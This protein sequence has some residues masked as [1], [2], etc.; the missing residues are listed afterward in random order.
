MTADWSPAT[1]SLDITTLGRLYRSGALKPTD[2]I[3][4]IYDRI[5]ARGDDHVWI[6]LAPRDA[7]LQHAAALESAGP[8]D[9][10]LWG[11]PYSVKDCNDVPGMPTTN[12]LPEMAYVPQTTGQAINRLIESGALCLGKVNMD[13]FGVGL[14][15]VRTPYGACSSVFGEDYISGGSSSGSGVSVAAGLVSFSVANDAAGSGRVP[16]AFN[17]IV[18]LKPTPGFI[19]NSSVSG[20]GS[21]KSAETM[22]VFALTTEDAVAV[23]RRMGGYDASY[24]F[25][26]PEADDVNL[27]IGPIPLQFRF[28]VP[29]GAAL[30]FFGD[31]EAA[32]LFASAVE[33]L[34]A[35]GGTKVEVD[36]TP[37]EET[38]KLLYGGPF[39]AERAISMDDVVAK[40][41]D[42]IHPV[43][44]S[45]LDT[46]SNHTAKDVFAA[47]HKVAALKRDTRAAWADIDVLVVPTTPTI[48]TKAEILA[49]PIRLNAQLGIYTNFV[50]LMGLCGMAV[51]NGFRPD[52]LPQGITFLAPSWQDA[53]VAS[54]GAAYHRETGL[55]L[56]ATGNPQPV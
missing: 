36:F 42:H 7:L 33:R 14:V 44:L 53:K 11:I 55:T 9:D 31:E 39:I 54:F 17:N 21:L 6:H 20:G 5:A 3:D 24:E 8:T 19:S 25:S 46:S 38:Q 41:R 1:G 2:V 47:I 29:A 45:I 43:T 15:G 52:G 12:A 13:Q 16:A 40:Y 27:V 50:N 49:D 28:G 18:G 34:E 22:T 48:Y 32:K 51:P 26:K 37:F 30:R 4:A 35:M 10:P 23:G 56:G